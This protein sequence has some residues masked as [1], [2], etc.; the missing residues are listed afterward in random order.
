MKTTSAR[1]RKKYFIFEII[2]LVVLALG[3]GGWW[4]YVNFAPHPLGDKL[5]YLG[6]RNY[7]CIIFCDVGPG[8]TYY[9][10]TNMSIEEV[11]RYFRQAKLDVPSR[12]ADWRSAGETSPRIHLTNQKTGKQFTI[13]YIENGNEI[14]TMYHLTPSNK[15]HVLEVDRDYYSSIKSSL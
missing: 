12:I 11:V 6:K 4:A 5:E 7:G 8:S 14:V 3:F 13:G 10:S 2:I 9:Y 15:L 1:F